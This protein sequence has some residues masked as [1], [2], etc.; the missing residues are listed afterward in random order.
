[1]V[2]AMVAWRG[3]NELNDVTNNRDDFVGLRIHTV[4]NPE[5]P[6][7]VELLMDDEGGGRQPNDRQRKV[8]HPPECK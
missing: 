6:N 3:K 7:K 1:M 5:A 4:M 8:V 2:N